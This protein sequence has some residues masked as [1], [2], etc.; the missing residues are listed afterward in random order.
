MESLTNDQVHPGRNGIALRL[1]KCAELV[2][3][4]LIILT[5][6]LELANVKC[7]IDQENCLGQL[8]WLTC[9]SC[10]P[11]GNNFLRVTISTF[12]QN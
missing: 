9:N 10:F 7:C 3:L 4:I 6:R 5:S 8:G 12:E 1:D 2:S 11:F